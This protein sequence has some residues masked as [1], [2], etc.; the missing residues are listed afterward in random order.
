MSPGPRRA[1]TIWLIAGLL[2]ALVAACSE[3]EGPRDGKWGHG[4]YVQEAWRIA[5]A[6]T[7]HRLHVGK[8]KQACSTCHAMTEDGMGEVEPSRCAACHEKQAHIEHASKEAAARLGAG[9]KADCTNCHAF[10]LDGS[11][12]EEALRI[13]DAPRPPGV[14]GSGGSAGAG[15]SSALNP[16]VPAYGPG[17]CKRCHATQQGD[18]P[19]VA[20]HGT[21]ECLSCH[22]P[23]E[24]AKPQSAPCADC[25]SQ[26]HTNHATKDKTPTQV[27][28][29]CHAD[30]HASAAAA[31]TG[32]ASCHSTQQPLIPATALFDGGHTACI[33]CH[34]PHDFD[35]KLAGDCRTCHGDQNVIGGGRIAAHDRCISCHA[36]HDVKASPAQ[37]CASCHQSV[38]PDH[39]K[40]GE[41]GTCVGCHDP[42]PATA[43]AGSSAKNCSSCHQFAASDKAAHG[44][45][46]C[47]KC[48]QPHQFKL[49]QAQHA[50]CSGCHA[51]R[52]Q[53]VTV[54]AGHQAC[55]SCH[56]GLPHRP[57]AMMKGCPTCHQSEQAQ[58]NA[59]HQQC[60]SCHEPHSGARQKD[61]ASC[62]K[63]EAATAPK[64][65]QACTSCHQPHSGSLGGK[66]CAT[67]HKQEAASP[68]GKLQQGCTN[69]HRPHGPDGVASAPA[70]T[71]CHERAKLPGL[72]SEP[73]HQPCNRCHS[74]HGEE[75][76][77]LREACL[78]CHQ[79]RKTHFP[80]AKRCANCHLFTP[81]Q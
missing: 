68:H 14:M 53:Q 6:V 66:V 22:R 73:K 77:M 4:V 16:A 54:N 71:T 32:C 9:V 44:G 69:C 63:P 76:S 42:H 56:A 40:R 48:H 17:D 52:V 72:H 30:Q 5:R 24:D 47:V 34:R 8:H 11:G 51:A 55:Q 62:H 45:V 7:G 33:G 13:L 59:G 60:Q 12:H 29:T 1:A 57:Q 36:P 46:E 50:V 3:A 35:P 70:C 26:V 58:V 25:H 23:H 20:V 2:F 78:S 74:G 39:P 18:V 43:H 81:T 28:Q 10:T 41:A 65:H 75:P 80:E 37:A 19:P 38:H 31:G 49:Q 64:G 67:C 79:D 21:Q 61:C 27:C 15:G